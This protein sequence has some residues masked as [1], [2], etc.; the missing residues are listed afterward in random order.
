VTPVAAA[1]AVAPGDAVP[2]AGV[3]EAAAVLVDVGLTDGDGELS[4]MVALAVA[5]ADGEAP[6]RPVFVHAE[7]RRRVTMVVEA[8]NEFLM[9]YTQGN[10]HATRT[11]HRRCRS[12]RR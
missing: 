2:L 7:R 10:R 5:V 8:K 6:D 12:T 9:R 3:G 1:V 11:R 4:A